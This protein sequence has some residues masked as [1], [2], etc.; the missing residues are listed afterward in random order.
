VNKSLPPIE[1]MVRNEF[2]FDD[3]NQTG[4]YTSG[5][6]VAVR[7]LKNQALQFSIL[8]KNGALFTG[9]P[10]WAL[11]HKPCPKLSP[12]DSQMWDN[13]S[14]NIDVFVIEQLKYMPCSVKL[15]SGKIE[16]GFYLFSIDFVGYTDLSAHPEH[17]KQLHFLFLKD[18][19]VTCYPQY[20]IQF[21][22]KAL[23]PDS[24][25]ALPKY[26]AN[27]NIWLVE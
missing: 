11:C 12:I 21:K 27:T 16:E 1:L 7:A 3:P 20:R 9:L 26:M 17:W 8:L 18:G 22:D 19:N 24:N 13:I 15:E 14:E 5:F 23:C 6:L 2:L 25:K 10:V 4:N